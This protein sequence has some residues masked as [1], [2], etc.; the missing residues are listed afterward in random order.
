MCVCVCAH[1]RSVM[2]DSLWPYGQQPPRFLCPWHPPGKNTGV[3]CHFRLQENLPD[4]GIEPVS[5][6]SLALAGR[7]FTTEPHEKMPHRCRSASN[8]INSQLP[9][10]FV[11]TGQW[12]SGP[13]LICWRFCLFSSE[14]F[15]PYVLISI[16]DYRFSIRKKNSAILNIYFPSSW[17]KIWPL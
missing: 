13:N 14:H 15:L 12:L 17:Q 3:D 10:F 9:A 2:S 8:T 6:A 5:P 11:E 1:A 7:F 16:E 4:Q